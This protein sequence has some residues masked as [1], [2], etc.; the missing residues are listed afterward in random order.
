MYDISQL[1]F[2]KRQCRFHASKLITIT[3]LYNKRNS[4]LRRNLLHLWKWN[5]GGRLK[6]QEQCW[7]GTKG[8]QFSNKFMLRY[9]NRS[10]TW[11]SQLKCYFFS[12]RSVKSNAQISAWKGKDLIKKIMPPL[13]E[14]LFGSRAPASHRWRFSNVTS[15]K[16][17]A[18]TPAWG[19]SLVNRSCDMNNEQEILHPRPALPQGVCT[20][21]L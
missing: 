1:L 8:R 19:G 14:A 20:F 17:K 3:K 10:L 6:Y 9:I 13:S 4:C 12:R 2:F 18:L 7:W 16:L 21:F 5:S 11:I 15:I